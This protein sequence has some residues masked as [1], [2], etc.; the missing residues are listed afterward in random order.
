MQCKCNALSAR[1]H[2]QSRGQRLTRSEPLIR[3]EEAGA[4][5]GG[6]GG[7]RGRRPRGPAAPQPITPTPP[8]PPRLAG[9]HRGGTGPPAAAP[10][11]PAPH[12]N[13]HNEKRKGGK[14]APSPALKSVSPPS[15]PRAAGARKL[16]TPESAG[17][18]AVPRDPRRGAWGFC[19]QRLI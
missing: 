10:P 14:K 9:T 2:N 13:S 1:Q 6:G 19:R 11:A 16:P 12:R 15:P 5:P 7:S 17:N 3:N 18:N 4:K 8:P